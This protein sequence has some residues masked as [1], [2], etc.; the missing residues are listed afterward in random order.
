M[1]GRKFSF[2][3]NAPR[4]L[5]VAKF[6]PRPS[7][8][9]DIRWQP[10]LLTVAITSLIKSNFSNLSRV[11]IKKYAKMSDRPEFTNVTRKNIALLATGISSSFLLPNETKPLKRFSLCTHCICLLIAISSNEM[12]MKSS[13][14]LTRSSLASS[15]KIESDCWLNP[16]GTLALLLACHALKVLNV[17]KRLEK[18]LRN[19]LYAFLLLQLNIRTNFLTL[20]P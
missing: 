17:G 15:V 10:V 1:N 2:Q 13:F 3:K 5:N 19:Q 9:K 7:N 11:L 16:Y 14:T 18:V 12:L 8:A 20:A 6:V 4:S